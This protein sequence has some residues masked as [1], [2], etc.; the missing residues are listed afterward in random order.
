[1][2]NVTED[3]LYKIIRKK[4]CHVNTKL[5]PDGSKAAIQ[6]TDDGNALSGPVNL[7]E[8]DPRESIRTEY[9]P[10]QTEPSAFI[11]KIWEEIIAPEMKKVLYQAMMEGYDSLCNQLK[12]KVVPVLKVKSNSFLK[13]SDVIISGIKDGFSGK[14]PKALKLVD[15]N[16]VG[17]KSQPSRDVTYPKKVRSREEIEQM[18]CVMR[19]SAV[20]LAACI[21]MINNS[22]MAD[23]GTDPQL[24]ITIQKK[25]Q[26]LSARDVM[27]QIDLLLEDKNRA[28]LDE[29]EYDVL[30][31]FK[32]GYL[33]ANESKVPI[34][35]Y[36][37][38]EE[39]GSIY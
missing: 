17:S 9:V 11:E 16:V 35:K 29:T 6:F 5:N 27:Q 3:K 32:E 34:V 28:L 14:V 38:D 25:L 22:I 18:I 31:L 21:R 12:R 23:D 37:N 19:S 4:D 2:E 1:M 26:E 36:L 8:V 10:M 13:K 24:R 33:L 20:K 7:I 15:E 39:E 30:S